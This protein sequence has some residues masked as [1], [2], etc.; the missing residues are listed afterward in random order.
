MMSDVLSD[1]HHD[2]LIDRDLAALPA[3]VQPLIDWLAADGAAWRASLPST[4]TVDA[5]VST[6][7]LGVVEPIDGVD[8]APVPDDPPSRPVPG[9]AALA[10]R[11][12]GSVRVSGR[13]AGLASVAAMV[14]VVTLIVGIFALQALGVHRGRT[15]ARPTATATPSPDTAW[16]DQSQLDVVTVNNVAMNQY[17]AV[18]PSDPRVVYEAYTQYTDPAKQNGQL[19]LRRSDDAGATWHTLPNPVPGEVSVEALITQVVFIVSPLDAHAVIVQIT[20]PSPLHQSFTCPAPFAQYVHYQAPC[21]PQYRSADGGAT[22]VPLLTPDY[23]V[24]NQT[25]LGLRPPRMPYWQGDEAAAL[26]AQGSRLYSAVYGP[27]GLCVR[28]VA[29]E[30]GGATWRTADDAL[31]AQGVQIQ[32]YAATPTGTTLFAVTS[33]GD[34]RCFSATVLT[35]WRSDDAGTTWH[36]VGQLPT[37]YDDGLVTVA[38]ADPAQPLL[39]LDA[40]GITGYAVDRL[41]GARSPFPSYLADDLKVSADGGHTW[42]SAPATGIPTGLRTFPGLLGTLADGSIVVGCV[43][44]FG[45]RPVPPT[46]PFGTGTNDPVTLYAWKLGDPTWRQLTPALAQGLNSLVITTAGGQDTLWVTNTTFHTTQQPGSTF[47]EPP[48]HYH[49]LRLRLP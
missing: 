40:P 11:R 47:Y 44:D 10:R 42:Q 43:P 45:A 33:P 9:P 21:Q 28:I 30:D 32:D 8:G 29:S 22:W 34:V 41:T 48:T 35:L 23:G 6:L 31:A 38:T 49:I 7:A 16:V 4:S 14:A 37:P 12:T 3:D 18:A 39:Y 24:P 5:A 46:S 13:L 26:R 15:A 19:V 1:M 36:R 27:D 2:P 25:L 20:L 17:P